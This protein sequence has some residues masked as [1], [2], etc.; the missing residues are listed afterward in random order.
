MSERNLKSKLGT[1]AQ[2]FSVNLL[3]NFFEPDENKR[4]EHDESLQ[5][6]DCDCK[7][8]K[9]LLKVVVNEIKNIHDYYEIENQCGVTQAAMSVYRVAKMY[10]SGFPDSFLALKDITKIGM[11]ISDSAETNYDAYALI[12]NNTQALVHILLHSSR[13]LLTD[14]KAASDAQLT[15]RLERDHAEKFVAFM[16]EANGKRF[17]FG[18]GLI[19]DSSFSPLIGKT[20]NMEGERLAS[21]VRNARAKVL[22]KGRKPTQTNIAQE[23]GT[24]RKTMMDRLKK[25]GLDLKTF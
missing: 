16:H 20:A 13:V 11:N 6:I 7:W 15:A 2:K 18:K 25:H 1:L 9:D 23:Y 5:H 14:F 22:A 19:D 24:P 3:F 8:E 12:E 21:D 10:I 17:E 4:N